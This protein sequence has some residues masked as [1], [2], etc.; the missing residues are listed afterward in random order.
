MKILV[1]GAGATGGYFG[2]RL[3][4]AGRDVTFLVRSRRAEQL[5]DGL[6]LIGLGGQETIAVRTVTPEHLTG[7]YDLVIIAVKAGALAPVL[8]QVAP[9]AG[10]DTLVLPFLNGM[11]HLPELNLRFGAERV[12]GGLVR[13]VT[14]V[15]AAGAIQQ[16]K[17]MAAMDFGPQ[18]GVATGRL[19]SLREELEVPG[20]ELALRTDI[21]DAMWKKWAFITAAGVV[22]CLMRGS[23][24]DIIAAGGQPFIDR[25]I[26]ET[27]RVATAAGHEVTAAE[28]AG[29]VRML[30]EPGS[31]FTSS[32]YRDVAAGLPHE[33]EHLLGHFAETAA[34]LGLE[35]PLTGL[36]LLQLRT[37]D[38]A[39]ARA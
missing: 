19:E 23:I 21:V 39:M 8:E 20:Y 4:Q 33:G 11:A 22:T 37:H 2:A 24:G 3:S 15:T 36:A 14:T 27:E 10:P 35:V 12:L 6:K 28:H 1:A 9:A 32:L 26:A 18:D 7:P 38:R 31:V 34:G 29:T 16:L 13:V 30:T 25:V 5:R 17:P